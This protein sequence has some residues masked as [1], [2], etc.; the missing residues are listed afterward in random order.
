MNRAPINK[1]I[2]MSSVDGPGNRTA[3]FFQGCNFRCTYCHNPETIGTCTHCGACVA[4]CPVGALRHQAERVA[5]DEEKC[6]A[7]DRCLAV[8]PQSASPRVHWMTVPEVVERIK[9][10]LPFIRGITV[11]GGECSLQRDFLVAL[12]REVGAL[13]LTVLMDSNGGIP[14]AQDAALMEVCDGVMLD[15]KCTEGA[16]H[17][18][19]TGKP[20]DPVL[21]NAKKLAALHKLVEV[22]TVVIPDVLPNEETVRTVCGMLS[23]FLCETDIRYKLIKFR[24]M[25]VR[26]PGEEYPSPTLEL[27][28]SLA[29]IAE[30]YGFS[31]TV[32]L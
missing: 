3:L 1:I 21:D 10:N 7:C 19:L 24:P 31:D 2:D 25:G 15:L 32:I 20:V 16:R 4:V 9:R 5:W 14:L 29:K 6:C 18:S 28:E 23:P 27:M 12:F 17:L 30:G 13:G 11:S 8:C 22:R 26:G